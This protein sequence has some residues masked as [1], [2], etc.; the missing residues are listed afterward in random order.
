MRKATLLS[1]MASVAFLVTAI[2]A[3]AQQFG[4]AAE[5]K[6][7]LEKAIAEVKANEA[8]AIEK[9]KKGEA[10]YK[11]RDLYVFC[12]DAKTGIVTAHP[13][14]I[15]TDIRVLKDKT[16][17]VI[18]EDIFAAAKDGTVTTVDYFFPK[19]GGTDPVA[20]QS[21]VTKVGGQGCAVG[22]YK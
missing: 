9:F 11:D 14:L 3:D 8:A 13:S 10:G 2:V 4:S 7:M 16:G 17:K 18:G 20:K 22:Y 5:A 6:A 21:F 1:A 15:G 12:F 19:P